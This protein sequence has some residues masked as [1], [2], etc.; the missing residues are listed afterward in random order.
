MRSY[1]L[2]STN[3]AIFSIY[4]LPILAQPAQ[5]LQNL[6]DGK[7]FYGEVPEANRIATQYMIFQKT[8]ETF[9]AFEYRS[10]TSDNSCL[11]GTISQ[12]T[13]NIQTIASPPD[14]G[15]DRLKWQFSSGKPFDF[16]KWYQLNISQLPDFGEKKLAEC[17]RA[18]S[19]KPDKN[20]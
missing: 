16:S 13:F 11:K 20:P 5:T 1:T 9:I 6:T 14:P 19:T 15:Y 18:F 4:C 8:G 10:N 2:L 7:Y 17:I 3:L 12:N